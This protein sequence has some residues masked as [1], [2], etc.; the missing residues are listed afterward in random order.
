MLKKGETMAANDKVSP[1]TAKFPGKGNFSPKKPKRD[2]DSNPFDI[3]KNKVYRV[4]SPVVSKLSS[5]YQMNN[6]EGASPRKVSILDPN[7][8]EEDKQEKIKITPLDSELVQKID[9]LKKR[10][11]KSIDSDDAVET[12]KKG[13]FKK[14]KSENIK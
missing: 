3:D 1:K 5:Q 13:K 2:M 7:Y 14:Y 4:T 8:S 9:N 10:F 12:E 11:S 6:I